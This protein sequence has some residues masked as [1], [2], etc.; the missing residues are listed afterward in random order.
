MNN[1][2]A[3][4]IYK[5]QRVT[6]VKRYLLVSALLTATVAMLCLYN[7]SVYRSYADIKRQ[8]KESRE[9]LQKVEADRDVLLEI[10]SSLIKD[11]EELREQNNAIEEQNRE[12]KTRMEALKKINEELIQQNNELQEDNIMLQNN[13]KKAAS[14]G[15]KPQNYGSFGGV[16]RSSVHRGEYIGRFLGTAYTPSV[17]ECGNDRGI[18]KSG[19]PIIPGL[20]IAVDNNYWPFGTVFYIKGLGYAVAMDTGSGVK[21]KYRFDFAVLDKNFA[22]K[23]G[24]DY[25]DVFLVRMGNGKVEDVNF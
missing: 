10:N 18:T 20:T 16:S 2:E 21:G 13:L 11:N 15:I 17:E 19:E 9:M 23:I 22:L 8:L 7:V 12:L 25:Y 6:I 14:V 5:P 4:Y 1:D 3:H 24:R